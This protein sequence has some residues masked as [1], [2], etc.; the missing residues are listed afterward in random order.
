[1]PPSDIEDLTRVPTRAQ[2]ACAVDSIR[3]A[4]A[5]GVRV[6]LHCL[7]GRDRTGLV[8]A[9]A[10]VRILG[11]TPAAAEKEMAAFGFSKERTPALWRAWEREMGER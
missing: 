10:R 2:L 8:W 9:L 7:H 1:M 4:L 6:Y 11:W 3:D 5:R